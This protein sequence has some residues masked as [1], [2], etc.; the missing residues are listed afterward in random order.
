MAV[1]VLNV[2]MEPFNQENSYKIAKCIII[3]SCQKK[4]QKKRGTH[5]L[6]DMDE[7]NNLGENCYPRCKKFNKL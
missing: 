7:L 3:M 4:M 2:T 5:N 1:C 6:E